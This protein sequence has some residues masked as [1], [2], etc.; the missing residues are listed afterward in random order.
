MFHSHYQEP[1]E[2]LQLSFQIFVEPK[3]MIFM[4][5]SWLDVTSALFSKKFKHVFLSYFISKSK[6]TLRVTS[7]QS[8]L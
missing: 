8:S 1:S 2:L 6:S 7:F 4:T 3:K 5:V